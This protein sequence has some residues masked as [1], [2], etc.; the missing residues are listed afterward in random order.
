MPDRREPGH[1]IVFWAFFLPPIVLSLISASTGILLGVLGAAGFA[2]FSIVKGRALSPVRVL[3]IL[4][5]PAFGL[6]GGA[7]VFLLGP[8]F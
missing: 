3:L 2:I 1:H 7:A 6:V 5:A 8:G 4:F